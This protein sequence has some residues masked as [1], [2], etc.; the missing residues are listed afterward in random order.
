VAF[1]VA[2]GLLIWPLRS[3]GFTIAT[4]QRAAAAA[5]RIAETL[6]AR[7][8][9]SEVERPVPL[10]PGGGGA[11]RFEGVGFD[12]GDGNGSVLDGFTLSVAAGETVALVGPTGSGKSTVARLLLR[13]REVSAGAILID[14]VDLRDLSLAEL[15]RNVA[16]VFEDVFLF[17]DTVAAN[18]AFARPD[19][20]RAEVERAA[21]LASAHD[22]ITE[23]A[24]G[25]DTV[26][27]E[28][29]FSL[30]GGQRQR[31]ALARALVADPRLLVLDD[32]TSAVDPA[33]EHEIRRGLS[34]ALA[35]RTTLV[36]SHRPATIA[37]ADR[38]VLL[39]R[40][41]VIAA[42]THDQLLATNPRY[43]EVLAAA[44]QGGDAPSA[45]AG[46]AQRD[47]GR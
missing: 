42:G 24:D 45:A 35:G 33:K 9:V 28:R 6:A 8:A 43:R 21:R 2:V 23:L 18:L 26:V 34:E 4:A 13:T 22:F 46:A 7:P 29:G 30:S 36:I 12:F 14:G 41:R 11:L 38:V 47:G 31:L 44:G 19:A 32:A 20:T 17:T 1:N 39:D 40:G 16:V 10:P 25:Y 37:L 27:G 3:L 5:E 15:R